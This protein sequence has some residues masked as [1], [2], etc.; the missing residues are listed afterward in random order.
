MAYLC[1]AFS[2]GAFA[3]EPRAQLDPFQTHEADPKVDPSEV[4]DALPRM[5]R[6]QAEFI[7]MPHATLTRLL[8][9]P[10]ESSSDSDLRAELDALLEK[11]EAR[12]LETMLCTTR[13]GQKA[14]SGAVREY[15][16]PTEYEP[17]E[18]PSTIRIDDSGEQLASDGTDFATGPT[19]TAFETRNLGSMFEITPIL[20]AN[21]R[22]IDLEF[23]PEIVYHVENE[24]WSEW[25]D[26]RGDASVRMPVFY[27]LR[28]NTDVTLVAG[29]TLLVGA[30]SPKN[31]E[32]VPDMDRKVMIFVRADV[33]K[34]N[35]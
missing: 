35:S 12:I 11:G 16:Y 26:K 9:K 2:A 7:E 1:L 10:R 28:I 29:Q 18:L 17:A 13:S 33:L 14:T 20:G 21:D 24:T 22:L 6:V 19:P 15:I 4:Q 23:A 34:V 32:G 27:V 3:Q 31:E 8:Q 30:V 25:K 5:I